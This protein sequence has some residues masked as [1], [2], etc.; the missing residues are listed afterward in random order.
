VFCGLLAILSG[1]GRRLWR[2]KRQPRRPQTE[3]GAKE[4]T[5]GPIIAAG[6]RICLISDASAREHPGMSLRIQ[7][8]RGALLHAC[9]GHYADRLVSLA[10]FG[11]WARGTATPAS[12]LDI[13]I[14]ARDLPRSRGKRVKDFA[15]IE[16]ATEA[17][18]RAVWRDYGAPCNLSPVIKTPEEVL[19]GSPLFLD[20][21]DWCDMLHDSGQF[22]KTYLDGLRARLARL[23]ACRRPRKGGYYW[24]YK[25]DAQPAEVIAL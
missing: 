15:P 23:G 16:D 13:L 2:R 1:E 3:I 25:P 19:A 5:M 4:K 21:T 18:R 8:V 10:V 24:E 11:S 22:L 12:D 7:P 6:A 9:R 14:V 17:A 20:M